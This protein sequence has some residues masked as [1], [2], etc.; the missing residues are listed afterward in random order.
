MALPIFVT[1]HHRPWKVNGGIEQHIQVFLRGLTARG[2]SARVL[3]PFEQ[4]AWLR[5]GALA[6][7]KLLRGAAQADW[8]ERSRAFLLE[9]SLRAA[10][11]PDAPALI[12]AQ[13]PISSAEAVK[14]KL[15]GYPLRV[16]Q[17]IHYNV[18]VAEEWLGKGM[19]KR[20]DRVFE[21]L[22]RRDR[23]LLP[24]LDR[25]VFVSEF[26]RREVLRQVPEAASVPS[27]VIPNCVF[28][29]EPV[30]ADAA[31]L[32]SIGTLEP[33]KNQ[34]FLLDVLAEA[35]KLGQAYSLD[36]IGGGVAGAL[37]AKAAA[38]GL[39]SRVRLLG[40]V[41]DAAAKLGNYRAYVHAAKMESFGIV[42]IE[43]MA[44][45]LPVFAAPVGGV[46]EVFSDGDGGRH[47]DLNNPA[48]AARKLVAVLEDPARY[49]A[50]SQAA[51]ARF[52]TN[53]SASAVTPRLLDAVL[54]GA[55][56]LEG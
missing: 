43:A 4:P 26:M 39:G 8:Y 35:D 28:P 10:L 38:L 51:A 27:F 18:S 24:Q 40:S 33:R 50:L 49:R 1:T 19:L 53:F 16:V 17:A 52:Q 21:R 20:G 13:D 15:A 47:W 12:Y 56:G 32:V 14:L 37:K 42:L 9:R 25:L 23:W 5:L 34:A 7:N 41:P 36:L 46:P 31:D 48:G 54:G 45:G 29:A 44:A 3:S 2:L 11:S 30:A 6:P 22:Q 55:A